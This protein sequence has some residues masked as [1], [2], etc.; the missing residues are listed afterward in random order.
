MRAPYALLR[1]RAIVAAQSAFDAGGDGVRDFILELGQICRLVF[2]L[3]GP[4]GAA[5]GGVDQL[6]CDTNFIAGAVHRASEQF[7]GMKEL[8]NVLRTVS[9]TFETHD[10]ALID[11][12]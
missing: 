8:C 3:P 9:T 7:I 5:A 2:K 11:Y 10:K 4:D 12:A 6:C 1:L